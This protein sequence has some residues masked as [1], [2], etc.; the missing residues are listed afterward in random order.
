MDKTTA[1]I[2]ALGFA[3]LVILAFFAVFRHRGKFKVK[4]PLVEFSAEGENAPPLTAPA[5]ADSATPKEIHHHHE[6]PAL[7]NSPPHSLLALPANFTG[8]DVELNGLMKQFISASNQD[9][10]NW[11]VVHGAPGVGKSALVNVLAHQLE[12]EYS[13]AQLHLDLRGADGHRKPVT[14]REAM[15]TVIHSFNPHEELQNLRDLEIVS[16]YRSVLHE[17]GRVLLFLDNAV[18]AEQIRPLLPPPN[19]ILLVTSRQQL[20]MDEL[21]PYRLDCLQP[22]KSQELL[23][24][25]APRLKGHEEEA[26]KLCGHLPLALKVFAGIIKSHNI[27][28]P[29]QLLDDFRNGR[30]KLDAVDAAFEVSYLYLNEFIRKRWCQLAVFAGSFDLRSATAMW[31]VAAIYDRQEKP[32]AADSTVAD[33]LNADTMQALVNANLVE[34][35][36]SSKRFR[37]HDLAWQFCE[38]K[39]SSADL[40]AVATA[41]SADLAP[42]RQRVEAILQIKDDAQ[43][44]SELKALIA[45]WPT[46]ESE[47]KKNRNAA[48]AF[49]KVLGTAFFSGLVTADQDRIARFEVDLALAQET[50]DRRGEGRALFNLAISYSLLK[51]HAQAIVHAEGALQIFEDIKDSAAI[52]VRKK[53]SEWRNQ[54]K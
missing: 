2:I 39:Q 9:A 26:A 38:R 32:M 49:E 36:Q 30:K 16:L 46:I 44:Q 13:D 18:S 47:V 19:C 11:L 8:R 17:G 33:S 29:K 12:R 20:F 48:K 10:T 40:V 52:K 50:S 24:A 53:L 25:I 54:T 37:L 42:I 1:I 6:A 45:D 7:H 31:E 5:V 3:A 43:L 41:I 28:E 21:T 15:E 22:D 35:I 34:W 51:D 27:T 23:I 4:G 14:P